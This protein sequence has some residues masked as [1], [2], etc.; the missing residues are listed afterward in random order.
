MHAKTFTHT[1]TLSTCICTHV[2]TLY[3]VA[4]EEEKMGVSKINKSSRDPQ[5]YS[6]DQDLVCYMQLH[7]VMLCRAQA[8]A[9]LCCFGYAY[10]HRRT[11]NH[12]MYV[13]AHSNWFVCVC[14]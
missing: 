5:T 10:V 11:C 12:K 3:P 7:V 13:A 6:C 14:H 9:M 2:R 8:V 1:H 4:A